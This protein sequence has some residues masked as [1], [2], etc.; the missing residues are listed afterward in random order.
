MWQTTVLKKQHKKYLSSDETEHQQTRIKKNHVLVLEQSWILW[1]WYLHKKWNNYNIPLVFIV[2]FSLEII[3]VQPVPPQRSALSFL[4]YNHGGSSSKSCHD[5]ELQKVGMDIKTCHSKSGPKIC[6]K[7]PLPL[8]FGRVLLKEGSDPT[9]AFY[10]LR[11]RR[12]PPS[13]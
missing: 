5:D 3:V 9:M 4:F 12:M 6:T 7:R 11:Y 2:I 10:T 1:S 8:P 13:S